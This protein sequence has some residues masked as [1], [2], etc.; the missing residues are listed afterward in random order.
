V[1][2]D[3]LAFAD[4]L[5]EAVRHYPCPA[6]REAVADLSLRRVAQRING[7]YESVVGTRRRPG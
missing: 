5:L 4:A 1:A 7:V 6:A 3:D 2:P